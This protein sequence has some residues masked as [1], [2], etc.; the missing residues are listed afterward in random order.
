MLLAE[1]T[2]Q[3]RGVLVCESP[4]LADAPVPQL[5]ECLGHLDRQPVHR[6]IVPVAVRGE[7]LGGAGR[8][9][10]SHRHDL[11]RGIVA[12]LRVRR[13]EEVGDAK[14]GLLGLAR[15]R[16][17]LELGGALAVCVDD[18]V[19]PVGVHRQV[20]PD[21][22]GDEQAFCLGLVE[23]GPELGSDTLFEVRVALTGLG[24]VAPLVAEER[25][26]VQ[27]RGDVV[28]RDALGDPGSEKRGREQL[29]VRPDLRRARRKGCRVDRGH[30]RAPPRGELAARELGPEAW[31]V[32]A[33]PLDLHQPVQQVQALERVLP[34]EDT[35]LVHGA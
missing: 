13:P 10:G 26:L 35:S 1:K 12:D 3:R 34:I 32:D 14:V 33:A 8:S 11:K 2:G 9:E 19:V 25:C 22:L 4:L 6:H 24:A 23:T 28:Q 29:V 31:V 17:T 16:E 7:Q 30:L 15:E 5:S 27:V 18:E 20:A 21:N